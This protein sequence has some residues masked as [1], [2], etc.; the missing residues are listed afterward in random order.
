MRTGKNPKRYSCQWIE[1]KKQ[2]EEF[3]EI[4]TCKLEKI[5]NA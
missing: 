2:E 1:N 5:S 4:N 3:F